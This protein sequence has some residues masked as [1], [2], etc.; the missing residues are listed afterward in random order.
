MQDEVCTHIQQPGLP[1]GVDACHEMD[2]CRVPLAMQIDCGFVLHLLPHEF[3]TG[4][5][6]NCP[7]IL[8]SR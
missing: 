1:R 2:V 8:L 4:M 6:P 5:L 3:Q 7:C